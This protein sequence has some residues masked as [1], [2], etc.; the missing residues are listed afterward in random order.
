MDNNTYT[1]L[2]RVVCWVGSPKAVEAFI[3]FASAVS[4]V[5]TH[6][7]SN[8]IVPAPAFLGRKV[9]VSNYLDDESTLYGVDQWGV[10][11]IPVR[12]SNPVG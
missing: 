3:K 9:Y 2:D 4:V 1:Q 10:V 5:A 7:P 12:A 6:D 11:C 8:K